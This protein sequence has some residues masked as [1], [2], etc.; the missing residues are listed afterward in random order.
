[1]DQ[2]QA[3]AAMRAQRGQTLIEF[4]LAAPLLLLFVLAL[5]DFGIAIDRRIVLQHAVREG[6]RYASV[7]GDVLTSGVPATEADILALTAS[8]SQGIVEAG[9]DGED[10]IAVCYA[11][12]NGNDVLGDAGDDVRVQIR[13]E[14]DF[15]TGFTS[16]F[17]LS[18]GS[19]VMEPEASARVERPLEGGGAPC[20]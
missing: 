12:R 17:N 3:R 8:Q 11:D 9:G 19:I 2:Y 7:G 1:M 18:T 14:H 16:L 6:V 10:G 15:V 4:A 20:G 13:Y 5:V